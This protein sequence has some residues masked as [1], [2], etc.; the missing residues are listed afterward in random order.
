M[1]IRLLLITL[2]CALAAAPGVQAQA[3]AP[4]RA[5]DTPL[6][7]QMAKM[8][9]AFT[10]LRA[11]ITDAT[12]NADSL[13]QIATIK[14]AATAGL[15]FEPAKKAEI[16]PADQAKFVSGFHEQLQ[17]LID[18]AGKLETALKAGDNAAAAKLLDDLGAT[19]KAG[20]KEYKQKKKKA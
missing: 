12:K 2:A 18:Q 11:N 1:K 13:K 3:P 14:T 6:S 15:K 9:D 5:F 8:N 20:H 19:Q 16:P 4:K 10:A 7:D 17:M